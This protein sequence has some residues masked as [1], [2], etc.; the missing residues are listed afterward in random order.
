MRNAYLAAMYELAGKDPR[1]IAAVADNGAIV[2]DKFRADYPE[3]FINFGIA[4]A[5]MVTVCAG[6]ASCGKIPFAYTIIPFLVMRAY[7]QVRNDVCLQRQNVKLIGVGGGLAYSALGPTHHAVEDIAVMRVLPQMTVI[8]PASPIEVYKATIAACQMN[9]PVYLR[10]EATKEPEIYNN[11]YQYEIGRGV[12]LHEGNA[13]TVVAAGSIVSDV[14]QVSRELEKQDINVRVINM[15]TI[16][17]IDQELL[18][19]A[20]TE[21]KA[22]VTVEEHSV[23]GGLG[24]A[25]AEV[26][27]ESGYPVIFE[28]MGLKDQFG[29]GYGTRPDIK[30]FNGI[31]QVCIF[32]KI[33]E[34]Y[35]RKIKN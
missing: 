15:P 30:A 10:L 17:P 5:T 20:A 2:Y 8:V 26:L 19:K 32:Q 13:V 28:R 6:L 24:G 34:I 11:S 14:L 12:V 3:Q 9:G 22:I 21:T 4:E 23:I 16:K 25:V 35:E 29:Q 1:I 27:L 18:L 7:E 33:L 31:S